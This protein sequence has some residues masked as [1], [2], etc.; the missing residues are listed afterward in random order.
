MLFGKLKQKTGRHDR[1]HSEAKN[2]NREQLFRP[3]SVLTRPNKVEL[4]T[5][6]ILGFQFG[7]KHVVVP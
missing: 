3:V 6:T 1:V 2:C 7:L 4:S 5:G